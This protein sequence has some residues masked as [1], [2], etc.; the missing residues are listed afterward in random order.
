MVRQIAA[1]ETELK[2]QNDS[3]A[4]KAQTVKWTP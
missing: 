1:L 3:C 4:L 2:Q